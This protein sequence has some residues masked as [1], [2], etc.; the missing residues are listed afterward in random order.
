MSERAV[1]DESKK[2]PL[3]NTDI[4][5]LLDGETNIFTYPMLESIDHIDEIFDPKGRAIMLFL[6]DGENSGHWISLIKRGNIIEIYDPYGHSPAE[7][8]TKLG[9]AM[10]DMRD[11]KQDRPLL[12]QKIKEAGYRMKVNKKQVQPV[13]KNIATCGRHSVMRLLFHQYPLEEYNAIIKKIQTETGISPDDL[14]TGLTAESLG[15]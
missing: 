14:A 15:K 9:G 12:Q 2:Y 13:S 11:W 6:T 5:S 10:T 4:Q 1:I 3:S 8:K 7:W